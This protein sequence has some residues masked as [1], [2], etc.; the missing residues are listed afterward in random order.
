MGVRPPAWL[1][2]LEMLNHPDIGH[3]HDEHWIIGSSIDSIQSLCGSL[4]GVS[5]RVCS[6][7]LPHNKVIACTFCKKA[8]HL[9]HIVKRY[10][11]RP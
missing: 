6:R 3:W 7:C 1:L 10:F 8:M 11:M 4:P 5:L 9:Q 2:R